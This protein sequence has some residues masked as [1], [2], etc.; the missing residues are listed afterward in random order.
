M[1]MVA[2]ASL[3]GVLKEFFPSVMVMVFCR[4]ANGQHNGLSLMLAAIKILS[5]SWVAE[6]GCS[7]NQYML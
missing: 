6:V 7:N 5:F 3:L 1:L 2:P 4:E